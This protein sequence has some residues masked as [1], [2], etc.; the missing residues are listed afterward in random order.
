MLK[1][2]ATAQ[3]LF[4]WHFQEYINAF[5]KTDILLRIQVSFFSALLK[6]G[7][8]KSMLRIARKHINKVVCFI[9]IVSFKFYYYAKHTTHQR[10]CS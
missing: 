1:K 7:K 3:A 9:T 5:I 4:F 6:N 8:S 10:K 2:T